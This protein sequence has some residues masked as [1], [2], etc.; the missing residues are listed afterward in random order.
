M[1]ID[2]VIISLERS[3][4]LMEIKMHMEVHNAPILDGTLIYTW[5]PIQRSVSAE[6]NPFLYSC[7]V[8]LKLNPLSSR[9]RTFIQDVLHTKGAGPNPRTIGT[10][11]SRVIQF[12][13]TEYS[14]IKAVSRLQTLI[15][16]R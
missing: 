9:M 13:V 10:G 12:T 14:I 2:C 1:K 4:S 8:L 6:P 3:D 5:V 11:W 7:Q 16:M 15:I